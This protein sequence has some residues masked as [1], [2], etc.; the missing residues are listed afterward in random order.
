MDKDDFQTF[1]EDYTG[2]IY[3]TCCR[4]VGRCDAEDVSQ[5]VLIKIYRNI[6]RFK[7][8][9]GLSTWIYRITVNTCREYW[10]KS[11]GY[12]K[13]AELKEESLIID[14]RIDDR[15]INEELKKYITE[16]LMAMDIEKRE[17][18]VLRDIEGL[19]YDEISRVLNIPV[20]TVKSRIARGRE[21][22]KKFLEELELL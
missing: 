8:K 2:K 15:I 9:S 10:R 13:R 16:A 3:S 6:D 14:S 17:A 20:G 1:V 4:L 18:V 5:D 12:N 11:R 7:G 19:S 21:Y 22:I